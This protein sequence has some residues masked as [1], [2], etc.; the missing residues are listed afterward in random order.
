MSASLFRT[1]AAL[2]LVASIIGLGGCTI[3]QPAEDPRMAGFEPD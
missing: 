2:G 3:L 1:N